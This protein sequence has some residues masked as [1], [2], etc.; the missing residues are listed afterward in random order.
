MDIRARRGLVA[1]S[2]LL[3]FGL[4]FSAYAFAQLRLGSFAQM[5]PGM[6][7]LLVGVTISGFGVALLVETW[8]KAKRPTATVDEAP[9]EAAD[10]RTLALVVLSIVVFALVIR[11]L[12]MG[13][14]IFGLVLVASFSSDELPPLKAL[15]LAAALTALG[16][17]VFVLAL[18]LP[19]KLLM[20]PF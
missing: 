15:M 11:R 1:G 5:G 14:A 8:L 4:F 9:P 20:W 7:P 3:A 16:W 19:I 6:F 13:P 17:L 2:A 10:W 18:G 12:G